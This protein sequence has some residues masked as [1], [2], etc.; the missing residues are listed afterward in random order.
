MAINMFEGLPGAGK[1]QEGVKLLTRTVSMGVGVVTNIEGIDPEKVAAYV[2]T[3]NFKCGKVKKLLYA[4]GRFLRITKRKPETE[5]TPRERQG[6]VIVVAREEMMKDSFY[7]DPDRPEIPSLLGARMPYFDECQEIFPR[8]KKLSPHVENYFTKHR[9]MISES[10]IS[11]NIVLITQDADNINPFVRSLVEMTIVCEKLKKAGLNNVYVTD[12]FQGGYQKPAC[13][14]GEAR[15][16]YDKTVYA[17]YKSYSGETKG[18]EIQV[19]DRQVFWKNPLFL[20]GLAVCVGVSVFGVHELWSF[21]HPAK[22]KQIQ[23]QEQAKAELQ[24]LT[25]KL[26][27]NG[28]PQLPDTAMGPQKSS[29]I[30]TDASTRLVGFYTTQGR[31]LLVVQDADGRMHYMTR[32]AGTEIDGPRTSVAINGKT[33]ATFT[34]NIARNDESAGKKLFK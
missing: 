23:K 15:Q 14:I 32:G 21:I 5:G 28:A 25:P 12:V 27:V 34:G 16:F 26:P 9:H 33:S 11:V 17:L 1:T 19:D 31:T 30:T 3:H 29:A 8:G 10:G 7:P 20:T 2:E 18:L 24:K 13:K 22:L 6:D 4:I